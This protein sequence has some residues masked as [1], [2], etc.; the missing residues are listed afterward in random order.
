MRAAALLVLAMVAVL[1]GAPSPAS[2]AGQNSL[3]DASASP[4]SGTTLTPFTFT[5]RYTGGFPAVS[6]RLD[7]AGITVPMLLREGTLTDGTWTATTVLPAGTWPTAFIAVA[8]QGKDPS[9]A[10][11]TVSV[12]SAVGPS[13]LEATARPA[14]PGGSPAS[15]PAGEPSGGGGGAKSTPAPAAPAADPTAAIDRAPAAPGEA[16]LPDDVGPA[17]SPV[18]APGDAPDATDAARAPSSA[19]DALTTAGS[20]AAVAAEGTAHATEPAGAVGGSSGVVELVAGIVAAAALGTFGLFLLLAA[21]RRRSPAAELPRSAAAERATADRVDAA[22]HR[23]MLR[24]ARIQLDE[25]PVL[26]AD[27]PPPHPARGIG[28]RSPPT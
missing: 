14:H 3:T 17:V 26:A 27:E 9:T 12:S 10:G 4:G 20:H 11:P 7:V 13:A 22:L 8:T 19:P 2:A 6:V 5:V 23:R 24:R 15:D 28:R 16:P 1:C 25:E 18:S 21:R